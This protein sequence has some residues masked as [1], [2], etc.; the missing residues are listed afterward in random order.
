MAKAR[1]AKR[2][3]RPPSP[4]VIK[5]KADKAAAVSAGEDPEAIEIPAI[6]DPMLLKAAEHIIE[7]HAGGRPKTYKPDFAKQAKKL[8]ELGA[9]D[10]DLAEF[11]GVTTVT[12]WRW[13]CEYK[14]FCN[15]L[16]IGKGVCDDRVERSLYQRAVGYSFSTEKIFSFQGSITRAPTVEHVPPD[17]GAAKLWLVNRKPN[18]WRDKVDVDATGT[19]TVNI[20]RGRS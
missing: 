3:V 4:E 15:A 6:L 7:K 20:V 11:F 18:D 17:P 1:G 16:M 13:R 10:A 14:E 19:V 9:T 8:C 12:I 2:S 5:A